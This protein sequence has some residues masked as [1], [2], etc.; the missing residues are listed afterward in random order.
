MLVLLPPSENKAE[1]PAGSPAVDLNALAFPE[2]REQRER[3]AATLE[4]LSRGPQT[5]A[6]AA[7]GLAKT[8]TAA[9]ERN[10]DLLTKPAAPAADVYT[11]VLYQQ[12]DLAT[13]STAARKKAAQQVLIASALWGI[14][15][16]DDCIPTYRMNMTAVLPRIGPLAK[17]WRPALA[18]ALPDAELVVVMRSQGYA[19]AW[20]PATGKVWEVKVFVE[21]GNQRK[22]I[23]HMAKH[24]RGDVARM[25]MQS[26]KTPGNPEAVA[27]I[28]EAAGLR[29]ELVPPSTAGKAW[30]LNV[31][32]N[33]LPSYAS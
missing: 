7:L 11:G 13:L 30:A 18:A 16:L 33:P 14:V 4:R 2:L 19:A 21:S 23:T 10:F 17:W 6:L 24:T 20:R 3:L 27:E 25:L 28:V 9:L 8:Q 5:K 22:V 12:L 26:G 15:R 31:I 29:T 1:P 32:R